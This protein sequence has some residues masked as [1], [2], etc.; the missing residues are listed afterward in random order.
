[1]ITL[2][3]AALASLSIVANFLREKSMLYRSTLPKALQVFVQPIM[4]VEEHMKMWKHKKVLKS[5]SLQSMLCRSSQNCSHFPPK[6]NQCK[7][8]LFNASNLKRH[9][10][11]YNTWEHLLADH[12]QSCEKEQFALHR[13]IQ[14]NLN[15]PDEMSPIQRGSW[16]LSACCQWERFR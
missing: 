14:E 15:L 3:D 16:T 8:S 7:S 11:T 13:E 9:M 1:M 5:F 10:K 12:R 4:D 2:W 6:C